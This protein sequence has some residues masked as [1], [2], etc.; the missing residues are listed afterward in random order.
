MEVSTLHALD[1]KLLT[2]LYRRSTFVIERGEGCTVF[3]TCG[4]SYLDFTSGIAVNALGHSHPQIQKAIVA[5]V[6]KIVHA[7]NLYL[8]SPMLELAELLV[9]HSFAD[10]VFFCNSGT[11]ANE[12]ALKFARKWAQKN[13]FPHKT[14][15]LAFRNG[16]HGRTMGALSVTEKEQYRKPFAPL[17]EDVSFADFNDIESVKRLLNEDFCAV[18]VEPIQGEG[19]IIPAENSFI[20]ELRKLC[21]QHH[22]LLIFDEV[23]CGLGRTGT[24]WAHEGFYPSVTPDIMTLAKPLGGGLPC[25]ATLTTE[26]VSQG[27]DPG[28]HGSTF[29]GNPVA[30]AAGVALLKHLLEPS[31]LASVREISDALVQGLKDLQSEFPLHINAIRGKGLMLGMDTLF[32][33]EEMISALAREGVIL[34][35]AG[36]HTLRLLPPLI[37]TL[38]QVEEFLQAVRKG[39]EYLIE[40]EQCAWRVLCKC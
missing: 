38:V 30:C 29:G 23:Q 24:L 22:T 5:Q 3:D 35:S 20:Y 9:S 39:L 12:A 17:I 18:I 34:V 25:G 8:T 13:S 15:F 40:K 26:R 31:F 10:K 16:F 37:L 19:G 33:A 11:E 32:S 6:N 36:S 4:K 14:R 27:M 21:D 2:G 28:D 7:S 1:S